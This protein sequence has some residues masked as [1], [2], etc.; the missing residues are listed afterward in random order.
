MNL[1][2][3]DF[4]NRT[5]RLADA[6]SVADAMEQNRIDIMTRLDKKA[7]ITYVQ[8]QIRSQDE[9]IDKEIGRIES[10]LTKAMSSDLINKAT[11]VTVGN[12]TEVKTLKK[13]MSDIVNLV[14]N[15]GRDVKVL[16]QA[17][18]RARRNEAMRHDG[19]VSTEE[20]PKASPDA[21]GTPDSHDHIIQRF[22][23]LTTDT[24]SNTNNCPK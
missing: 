24:V 18:Q 7:E 17:G 13:S 23:N 16:K 11:S 4:T 8:T 3:E 2:V 6:A 19:V 20:V 12:K 10:T 1:C 5:S 15:L 21:R 14:T 9:Y 22:D